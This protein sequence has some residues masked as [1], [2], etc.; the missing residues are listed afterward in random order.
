MRRTPYLLLVAMTLML[1]ATTCS[2]SRED[3]PEEQKEKQE[4]KKVEDWENEDING[5]ATMAPG[6]MQF[7]V[8]NMTSVTRGATSFNGA[9]H[10]FSPG[11]RVTIEMYR[12]SVK[13]GT[14]KYKVV[15]DETEAKLK[16]EFDDTGLPFAWENKLESVKLRAWSYGTSEAYTTDPIDDDNPFSLN[17]NQAEATAGRDNYRELLYSPQQDYSYTSG[18]VE[19][20]LYHQMSRLTVELTHSKTTEDLAVTANSVVIGDGTLPVTGKFS[21]AGID[22]L[23]DD[24][25][26]SW[27]ND[28]F[29]Y[30]TENN[31]GKI[32]ARTDVA[33]QKYSVVLFP[34]EIASGKR[35]ITLQ[36]ADGT[37]AYKLPSAITLLPGKQYNYTINVKDL[38]PVTELT[39]SEITGT[40]TYNGS[41]HTPE[42][43]SVTYG[44]KILVKDTDY[45]LEWLN[46]TNAGTATCRVKG[47]GSVF[48]GYVDKTFTIAPKAVTVTAS[49]QEVTYG[50]AITNNTTK[51]TSSGL[52]DGHSV[53]AITLTPSTTNATNDGTITPSAGTITDGLSNNVTSNYDITYNTGSLT[54]NK[55]ALT[56]TASAQTVTYG[57]AITNNTT[58]I[59]SSGLVSGHSVT[60]ITLTPST[61]NAT[62]SGTITP[63]AGT[64]KDG[65]NNEVTTNYN[66]SYNTGSLIINKK[67]ATITLSK[68]SILVADVSSDTFMAILSESES[69]TTITATSGNSSYYTSTAGSISS[70]SSTVT[71]TGV[72]DGTAT[73]TISASSNNYTYTDVTCSVSIR[74]QKKN[75]LWWINKANEATSTNSYSSY[76]VGGKTEY[77]Y[78]WFKAMQ[79]WSNNQ[80]PRTA[81]TAGNKNSTVSG[82]TGKWH[83]GVLGE[84]NSVLPY[85]N[86]FAFTY[87]SGKYTPDFSSDN[88]KYCFGYD[89]SSKTLKSETSRFIQVSGSSTKIAYAIRF[90]GTDYCSAWKWV[91][92]DNSA[93]ASSPRKIL[94]YSML[95][96]KLSSVSAADSWSTTTNWQNVEAIW[97]Q[98]GENSDNGLACRRSLVCAGYPY[99]GE[100]GVNGYYWP[101]TGNTSGTSVYPICITLRAS[102]IDTYQTAWNQDEGR[103]VRTFHD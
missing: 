34:G 79:N 99:N 101:A 72:A 12:G 52:V 5:D 95:I 54:V 85:Q 80:T 59:T 16:L 82:A 103:S 26:G 64:V 18:D 40:Y 3:D 89:F 66:I 94:I 69:S 60:G 6:L 32:V 50:T 68:S 47:K 96:D 11:D 88:Y 28:G 4:D 84:W 93:T 55:K 25:I 36:T 57:T 48:T 8:G 43:A 33:N 63:S 86:I 92:Q 45:E 56:I 21:E 10:T 15:Y 20:K 37:F 75:P 77:Y 83:M 2:C 9:S 27:K 61:T 46:N 65:S 71:I 78:N 24:Y 1:S 98:M 31:T 74:A 67:A 19:L 73:C 17:K 35:L 62:N 22:I 102:G 29:T 44:D 76:S 41:A 58:K 49:A 14:K 91:I 23:N 81:W 42:P 87:S 39:I 51:I 13:V 90:I 30:D 100:Y 38:V 97:N 53:T 7:S 70:S